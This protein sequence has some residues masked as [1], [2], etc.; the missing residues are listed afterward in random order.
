M[1]LPEGL[2][3]AKLLDYFVDHLNEVPP[4]GWLYVR[5][6]IN[7]ITLSTECYPVE[8]DS[9]EVSEKE[10]VGFE[11]AWK[12]AGYRSFLCDGQIR[13]IIDNLAEQR[14]D[15]TRPDLER[16]IDFYWRHDAFIAVN[17]DVA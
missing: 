15:F 3:N 10:M 6:D 16:A 5:A 11:T 9:R 8:V 7:Q 14:A 2:G 13:E 4:F 1:P 12:A 17:G